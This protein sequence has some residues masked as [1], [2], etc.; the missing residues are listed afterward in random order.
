MAEERP[1]AQRLPAGQH[2]IPAELVARNQRERLIAAMAEA[3]AEKGYA[4]VAVADVVGRAGV[5][6][7]TFYK[8]F[9]SKRACLLAAHA[10]L[11]ARLLEEVDAAG[12]T[13][14]D[15]EQRVRA[16]IATCLELFAADPPTARLLTVEILAAGP[17]GSAQQAR[18]I[19]D[20]AR[21]LRAVADA[22][23]GTDVGDAEWAAVA[24]LTALV[25]RQVMAGEA[26][27]LPG[28]EEELTRIVLA[29]H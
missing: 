12:A 4:E 8:R 16:A 26:G 19:A 15:G 6:T 17:E 7:A 3:C 27:S 2:G 29:A 1:E 20:L 9:D 21:R 14:P 23:T 13:V 10:E 22:G 28:L 25:A 24:S 18:A 11:F 5:S